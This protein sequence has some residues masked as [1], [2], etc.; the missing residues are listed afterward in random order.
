MSYYLRVYD[1]FHYMDEKEAYNTAEVPTFR[2]VLKQAQW[3]IQESILDYWIS[4][5]P[6]QE[7]ENSWFTYGLDP[8]IYAV[9]PDTLDFF[10]S[11]RDFA[12][13]AIQSLALSL[14]DERLSI[15]SV[16][17]KTLLFAAERHARNNQT[18]PGTS[19]PYVVHLSN[20]SME[21]FLAERSSEAFNLKLALQIA[22]LH[23]VLED[24]N[25][26]LEELCEIFGIGVCACVGA[27]TK[28]KNLPREEQIADS[29]SRIKKLPKEVWA[30]K[31]SDRITNLQPPPA[32]WDKE[33]I[34]RYQL[35][36][37]LILQE[38]G[39]GNTY[40]KERLESEIINYEKYC[41]C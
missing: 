29:L 3:L 31:L 33:K 13:E 7:M 5:I 9:K 8:K 23:D 20:V 28:N 17:Q 36:A 12:R 30:V 40:L 38:L 32:H 39:E 35:E 41:S 26:S 18:L 25:T 16:Y 6:L 1:N 34:R 15:Q 2:E 24:T 10:F 22:L 4:G 11:G 21:I 14:E 27:L 37:R 19:I